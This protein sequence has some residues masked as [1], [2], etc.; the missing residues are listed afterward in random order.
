MALFSFGKRQCFGHAGFPFAQVL[1]RK[2][3]LSS[4]LLQK[5]INMRI[6]NQ[7]LNSKEKLCSALI[8]FSE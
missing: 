2:G 3:H 1:G 4:Q 7:G 6:Q 5:K 8:T